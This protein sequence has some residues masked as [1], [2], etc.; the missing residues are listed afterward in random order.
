GAAAAD[1]GA[2]VGSLLDGARDAPYD[3]SIESTAPAPDATTPADAG[4]AASPP[5]HAASWSLRF[6]DSQDQHV[7]AVAADAAGDLF[8]AGAFAGSIDFGGGVALAS[9]GGDDAFVAMLDPQGKAIWARGFGDTAD[10]GANPQRAYGVAV[11]AAGDVFVCGAFAGTL[12]ATTTPVLSEEGLDGFVVKLDAMGTVQW[13]RSFAGPGDQSVSSIASDATGTTVVEGA[14]EYS[15][16]VNGTTVPNTGGFDAFTVR[17]NPNG[18]PL[19]SATLGGPDDQIGTA[20]AIAD[21]GVPFAT[22]YVAGRANVGTNVDAGVVTSA[23]GYDVFLASFAANN[24]NPGL[25]T[26]FGD[27]ADQYGYAL[28]VD[29]LGGGHVV[30]AGPFAGTLTFGAQPLVSAGLHDVFV[31]RF[32]LSGA[33]AWGVRIG[34]PQEQVA[35]G[36][37]IDLG[38]N[39]LVAGSLQ[40]TAT[41]G[42]ETVVGAGGDDALLAK[43]DPDGKPLWIDRFGDPSEQS[44]TAVTTTLAGGAYDVVLAGNFEG[45]IDLGAGPLTSQG[46]TDFFLAV[47]PP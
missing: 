44:A 2:D 11:D 9:T 38:G 34:D 25:V 32:D 6:G 26:S 42:S 18:S 14:F 27:P 19:W 36:T 37:A 45:T 23:G 35:Y 41:F 33:P 4:P 12:V 31:A 46:G 24:G 28:A 29:S 5:A 40:G 21:G 43:L 15:M 3:A 1:A 30:V 10:G 20:V 22:G 7:Y 13:I 16:D 47:F 17:L 8:V 39:V